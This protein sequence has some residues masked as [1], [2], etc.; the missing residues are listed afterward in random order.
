LGKKEDTQ[1]M[2]VNSFFISS[3]FFF[4]LVLMWTQLATA[5]VHM[6]KR[7]RHLV[8][9]SLEKTK[10]RIL[11]SW[12][13]KRNRARLHHTRQLF[14]LQRPCTLSRVRQMASVCS[15]GRRLTCGL[16]HL[17]SFGGVVLGEEESSMIVKYL[18]NKKALM[19]DFPFVFHSP[20]SNIDIPV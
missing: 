6:E 16:C 14:F 2:R 3:V 17:F 18:G 10:G 9:R 11:M 15:S 12:D 5:T 8:R 4:R 7:S 20:L 19:Y 1:C 13:A